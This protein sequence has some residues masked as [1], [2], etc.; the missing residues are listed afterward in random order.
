M[1][2]IVV[3]GSLAY[4]YIMDYPGNFR[5]H[6][7]PEGD[8]MI[9]VSFL[10][11]SMKRMRGGVAGNIAY[12]LALLGERP[13]VMGSVGQD[14]GEYRE[15][16]K[17][18]GM[19][20]SG[21][22]EMEDEFTASAFINTDMSDNQIV[23]FYPGAMTRSAELSLE[24]L[25]LGPEDFVI[26]SPT[27]P[28]A[29]SR[30]A[31]ECRRMGVPFLFDPGKQTPRL[32]GDRIMDGL[33]GASALIGN[34]YEFAMM[35]RSTG[36]NVEELVAAAPLTVLTRGEKGSTIYANEVGEEIQLPAAPIREVVD[37]TGAGDAYLGGFVFGMS[38]E[39]PFEVCGRIAALSAAYAVE[40]RGCQEH[41]F[42]IAEFAER[43]AEA[44]VT[45][46]E[47]DALAEGAL[48]K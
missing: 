12:S 25:G 47:I 16:M 33:N 29:M 17:S 26:I 14:F 31:G 39:F 5:D 41:G 30:Y 6:I 24:S 43:Y 28:E 9:S 15:W 40:E 46:P 13:L 3:T 18:K 20:P 38:Q 45:S 27:D 35:S 10:V 4:D 23:A 22:A 21:I 34:D 2:R 44:F 1:R 8:H 42:T 48:K 37:P 36:K 7:I 11:D 19:D 32:D